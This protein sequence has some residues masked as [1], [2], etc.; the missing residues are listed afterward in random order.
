[1]RSDP[2]LRGRWGLSL[3]LVLGLA[4]GAEAATYWLDS[5]TEFQSYSLLSYRGRGPADPLF[6]PRRRVV[7]SLGVYGFE[8]VRGLDLRFESNLRVFADLAV[9]RG[10]PSLV[11]GLKADDVELLQASLLLRERGFE[12]QLGRQ[13]QWGALDVTALDGLRLS[14]QTPWGVGLESYVGWEVRG[15]SLLG[16]SVYQPDG[17]R[18][19]DARRLALGVELADPVLDD[20]ALVYGAN[21]FFAGVAGVEASL[22]YRRSVVAE[23]TDLE[24]GTARLSYR[25][26]SGLSVFATADADLLQEQLGQARAELRYDSLGYAVSVEAFRV[27]PLLS[28]DSIWAYFAIAPRDELGVRA[29][30]SLT[31]EVRIYSRLNLSRNYAALNQDGRLHTFLED[32]LAPAPY[33]WGAASGV[34]WSPSAWNLGLDGNGRLGGLNTSLWI[35]ALASWAPSPLQGSVGTRLSA[36]WLKDVTNTRLMRWFFGGQL[37]GRYP[38]SEGVNV[39]AVLE[40]NF[41]PIR[42]DWRGSVAVEWSAR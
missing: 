1:M 20:P 31:P 14:Y 36:A 37:W 5:R 4:P 16:S 33:T 23:R 24:R 34:H 17:T 15:Q 27:N 19:S 13:L 18:E 9:P 7:Q 21:L 10:E 8:L 2:R 41:N 12:A 25:H 32:P 39:V 28:A 40:H 38:L 6:L 3:L 30:L 35:D 29:D 26:P 42:G 11:E 22:G